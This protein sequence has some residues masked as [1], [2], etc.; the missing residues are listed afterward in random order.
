MRHI[1]ISRLPSIALSAVLLAGLAACGTQPADTSGPVY[2]YP[3]NTYPYSAPGYVEYGRVTGVEVIRI[4]EPGQGTGA[5]VV[6]GGITGAVI[7]NQIGS[8]SGRDAA[9]IAGV[10]GGA[11][12]GNAIEKNA[13]T[14]TREIY[15]ISVQVDNGSYRS[16]DVVSFGGLRVGDRVRIENNQLYR[17]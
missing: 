6:I 10:V 4:Q 11:I 12:V 14:E 5:G 9:R 15:R 1:H 17:L 2:S 13:R 7:G 16:Y 3:A 8:G